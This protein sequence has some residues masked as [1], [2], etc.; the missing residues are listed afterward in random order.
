MK[1]KTGL[2]VLAAAMYIPAGSMA[3][4]YNLSIDEISE[5][6]L[7]A[8]IRYIWGCPRRILPLI[9]LSCPTGR[10]ME[11][12]VRQ[13]RRNG[14]SPRMASPSSR[15]CL[16]RRPMVLRAEKSWHLKIIS[17]RRTAKLP[18]ICM[19]VCRQ[20]FIPI[21]KIFLPARAAR[22]SAGYRMTSRS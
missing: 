20:R 5:H 12:M 2:A 7:T 15:A 3:F 18:G 22:K 17:R 19:P 6:P 1:W 4:D 16:L 11:V 9:F 14:L 8:Y 13:K 21:W 10:S